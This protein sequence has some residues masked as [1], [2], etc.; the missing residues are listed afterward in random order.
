MDILEKESEMDIKSEFSV[1][2]KRLETLMD[3]QGLTA[4]VLGRQDNFSWL[5]CGGNGAVVVFGD[6]ACAALLL[7]RDGK[8]YVLTDNIEADRLLEEQNLGELGFEALTYPWG[9]SPQSSLIRSKTGSPAAIGCDAG[10]EYRDVAGAVAA[11]RAELT[12]NERERYLFLG[13]RLSLAVESVMLELRPGMTEGDALGRIAARLW[14]DRIDLITLLAAFDDRIRRFR[15]PVS[16]NRKLE[17]FAMLSVN[18]RYKGLVATITRLG[19]VGKIDPDHRRLYAAAAAIECRMISKTVPGA[20]DRDVLRTAVD[21]YAE[22]GFPGEEKKHHQGGSM[23]YQPRDS[24]AT[25]AS[26]KTVRLHQAYCW[27]PTITGA[28]SEDGFIV[29]ENGPVFIT[30]PAV[31]PAIDLSAGGIAFKRPDFVEI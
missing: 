7:T 1:K 21:A 11:C 31:F 14:T 24:I 30:G 5:S 19:H 12:G 29:G 28:K 8:N 6:L 15:H 10:G 2:R 13:K 17:R 20:K 9:E 18:A 23:G 27:N 25:P 16:V 22:F 4:L 26:D 3:E